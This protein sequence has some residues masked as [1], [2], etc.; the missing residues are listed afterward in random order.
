M[1]LLCANSELLLPHSY[2]CMRSL[3]DCLVNIFML[4][5]RTQSQRDRKVVRGVPEQ[6][7][8]RLV[9]REGQVLDM[10]WSTTDLCYGRTRLDDTD[11]GESPIAPKLISLLSECLSNVAN[12]V[13]QTRRRKVLEPID[14]QVLFVT[15]KLESD[16][17]RETV[18]SQSSRFAVP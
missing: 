15:P 17:H 7:G 3:R 4:Y 8:M 10:R 11:H 16:R 6:T 2:A 18:A 14:R 9:I 13:T 1:I 12:C 5:Q